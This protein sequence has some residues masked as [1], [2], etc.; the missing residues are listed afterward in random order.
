[1]GLSGFQIIR[2]IIF[3]TCLPSII[4]GSRTSVNLSLTLLVAAEMLGAQKGLGFWILTSSGNMMFDQ[5]LAGVVC[6]SLLGLSLNVI[7]DHAHKKLCP[8][9]P[10]VYNKE[11][12]NVANNF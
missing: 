12:I 6:L 2:G 3:P 11:K 1:M 8:W 10:A 4:Q 9:D 7:I 5:A